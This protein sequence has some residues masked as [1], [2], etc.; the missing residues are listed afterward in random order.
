[1][2]EILIKNTN[3]L[4][5][6]LEFQVGKHIKF[7]LGEVAKKVEQVV[8]DYVMENWYNAYTPTQYTRTYEFINSLTISKVEE[9]GNGQYSVVLF[10][11]T[12]KIYPS[13]PDGIGRW[14]RH[15]SIT[16]VE[17]DGGTPRL[18]DDVS[19]WIPYWISEGQN[20]PIY[21]ALHDDRFKGIKIP[22]NVKKKVEETSIH[23]K[24][25]SRILR[26]KGINVTWKK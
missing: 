15:A 21:G 4:K 14:S 18:N 17:W 12:N 13:A 19:D 20:S 9:L 25:I 16:E 5:K 11:D 22:E 1:M 10:F 8:K 24:E 23:L 7:A 6:L 3:D 26:A 2:A